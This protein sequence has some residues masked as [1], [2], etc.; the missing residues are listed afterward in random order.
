MGYFLGYFAAICLS[1]DMAMCP[2]V[3]LCALV[4]NRPTCPVVMCCNVVNVESFIPLQ[5]Q[6]G[7]EELARQTQTERD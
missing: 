1:H 4:S 7:H 6:R 3:C 5:G 2:F